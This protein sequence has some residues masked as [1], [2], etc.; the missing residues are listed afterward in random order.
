MVSKL[1]A[2]SL[3]ASLLCFSGV[4][5]A[6]DELHAIMWPKTLVSPPTDL[7]VDDIRI[8]LACGE[9][10]AVRNIP[11]DWNVEVTRPVSGQS[12]LHLSAGHGA[13]DLPSLSSLN[14]VIIVSGDAE[15]CFDHAAT[16]TTQTTEKKLTTTDISLAKEAR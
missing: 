12:E 5:V 8:V 7:R 6:G 9:F 15:K 3:V 4:A 10:R 14:G 11:P 16:V 2:I 1:S 13:S